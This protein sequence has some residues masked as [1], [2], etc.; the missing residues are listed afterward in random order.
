MTTRSIES[1][2]TLPKRLLSCAF[3]AGTPSPLYPAVPVPA[4]VEIV[5]GPEGQATDGDTVN[6]VAFDCACTE[7]HAKLADAHAVFDTLVV[8]DAE[9]KNETATLEG[10]NGSKE[11]LPISEIILRLKAEIESR[12]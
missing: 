2:R 6:P 8:G 10:R 12:L 9:I 5:P 1:T 3:V 4:M 11:A 7:P